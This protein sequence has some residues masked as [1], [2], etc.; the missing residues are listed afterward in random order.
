MNIPDISKKISDLHKVL[1]LV[2]D[3]PDEIAHQINS[4]LLFG[5]SVPQQ[6]ISAAWDHFFATK[7]GV[8]KSCGV[9]E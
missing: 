6:L 8:V 4:I 5:E 9:S 3:S 7:K 1:K 2:V